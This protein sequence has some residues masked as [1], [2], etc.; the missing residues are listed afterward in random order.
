MLQYVDE[1]KYARVSPLLSRREASRSATRRHVVSSSHRLASSA[2]SSRFAARTHATRDARS[3]AAAAAAGATNH[4]SPSAAKA[5]SASGPIHR[6][7]RP[8]LA[9]A[10]T[11]AATA[12][13]VRDA[14]VQRA[15]ARGVGGVGEEFRVA[16]RNA[17]G[18][19]DR[20]TGNVRRGT[21]AFSAEGSEGEE[22]GDCAGDWGGGHGERR[23]E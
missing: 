12:T 21:F 2:A 22:R 16:T 9:D 4:H 14:R 8:I 23:R 1:E 20:G 7:A 6:G 3:F 17:A 5:A 18:N 19:G 11:A 15:Y 13:P 10:P